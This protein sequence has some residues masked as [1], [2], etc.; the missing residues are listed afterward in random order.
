MC[1]FSDLIEH[2]DRIGVRIINLSMGSN[3]AEDW[4]CF[5]ESA[6]RH[7]DIL[8]VVSLFVCIL[9]LMLRVFLLLLCGFLRRSRFKNIRRF[10]EVTGSLYFVSLFV[11]FCL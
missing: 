1:R 7:K 6:N 5:C 4:E 3:S 8:F 11:F 9:V 10:F 2:A